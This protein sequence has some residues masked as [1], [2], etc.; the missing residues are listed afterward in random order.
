MLNTRFGYIISGDTFPC[1]NVA[2]SLHAEETD[3]DHVVKKFWETEKVPEVFLESLPEH[4]Q[5]ER[6][7]QESVTLQNNRFEVGL[8]LKMSQ[9][10]I[11]TSS[12]FAIALQRFYNLEKRFSKDPLYYQLYVEFIHEYLKLGHAKIINM[13]D[14]DSPNIQP[15]YFL[16]HHAVIRNYKI[17]N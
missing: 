3:L 6:V 15:L 4:A 8:P 13:D 11:N 17:T 12:S 2:T 9:S 1:C 16:S 10:D 7:F 14:N 5:S